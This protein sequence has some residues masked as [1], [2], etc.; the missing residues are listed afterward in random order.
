LLNIDKKK[1]GAG[2]NKP[3]KRRGTASDKSKKPNFK[4][5]T[6]TF[7]MWL[8]IIA[9]VFLGLRFFQKTGDMKEQ[10]LTYSQFQS[11]VAMP[12]AK[13]VKLE[14]DLKGI[15]RAVAHG[16]VADASALPKIV[17]QKQLTGAKAFT[18]ILPF[19]DSSMLKEWDSHNI[20]YSFCRKIQLG[21]HDMEQPVL[22]SSH[23]AHLDVHAPADAGGAEGNILFWKE[24]GKTAHNGQAAEHVCRRRRPRRSQGRARGDNR[25]S[26][27]SPEVQAAG[28][29]IPKGVLLLGPPEPA[30]RCLRAALRAR[31]ACPFSP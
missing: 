9:V 15:N 27:E 31:R 10:T 18:V 28:R 12:D 29:K 2:A 17:P 19:L 1:Q 22:A 11:L 5:P 25:V 24:Q 8:L 26:Q 3:V 13:I 4:E 16:E 6:R 23:G 7:A 30:K 21:R 20:Q 14:I